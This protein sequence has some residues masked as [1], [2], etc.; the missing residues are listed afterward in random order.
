[1]ELVAKSSL[2]KHHTHGEIYDVFVRIGFCMLILRLFSGVFI[3]EFGYVF[4]G[5]A[6]ICTT[7]NVCLKVQ[8]GLIV[9]SLPFCFLRQPK[10]CS[11]AL[12]A[13]VA[14]YGLNMLLFVN[15]IPLIVHE[16]KSIAAQ[17][18]FPLL[19][20]LSVDVKTVWKDI[21]LFG[22]IGAAMCLLL[23]LVYVTGKN[24]LHET[25]NYDMTYSYALIVP[26]LILMATFF[27]ERKLFNLLVS[28]V[29]LL[30][31]VKF[32][33]RGP[34]LCYLAGGV[35]MLIAYLKTKLKK[36]EI[37]T[38]AV[39]KQN[40]GFALCVVLVGVLVVLAGIFVL[41][42]MGIKTG[43][44]SLDTM[45]VSGGSDSGRSEFHYVPS[46]KHIADD[47]IFAGDGLFSDR[48]YLYEHI[49]SVAHHRL[50][51][52]ESMYGCYCHNMLLE[53]VFHF[54]IIIG[55]AVFAGF[56]W[57]VIAALR[58]RECIWVVCI[59]TGLSFAL[60]VSGSYLT[61]AALW[62][63]TGLCINILVGKRWETE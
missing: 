23:T 6:L 50:P 25:S 54:G 46:I 60:L 35:L 24:S 12:I 31:I 61:Y 39:A 16:V 59:F 28:F 15:T 49:K 3:S 45:I 57:L 41:K 44:R 38:E 47:S 5:N 33:A 42:S 7:L 13:T 34:V 62:I 40:F 29:L 63:L 58:R 14:V 27:A 2:I 52:S 22:C 11:V 53:I 43:I 55:I 32:G 19:I 18:L 26:A 1:M 51:D 48:Q 21:K 56:V 17:M 4:S 37:R 9:L 30:C 36:K 20:C 8:N 10:R